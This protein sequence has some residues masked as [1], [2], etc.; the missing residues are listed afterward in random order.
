MFI[1][2]FAAC[3]LGTM[4]QGSTEAVSNTLSVGWGG[5][6]GEAVYEKFFFVYFGP[7]GSTLILGFIY[8][9][10]LMFIL[11]PDVRQEL[12]KLLANFH[13]WREERARLRAE[14]AEARRIRREADEKARAVAAEAEA[15]AVLAAE[16][17]AAA[18]AKRNAELKVTRGASPPPPLPLPPPFQPRCPPRPR[19][20]PSHR[21]FPP[22]TPLPS[23]R[24]RNPARP[25]RP[26]FPLRRKTINSPRSRSSK[27]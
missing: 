19:L 7:I 17:A 2:L 18:E 22:A 4:F 24:P 12:D 27:N 20:L 23:S 11:T 10:G 14:L 15:K 13:R 5:Q 1:C 21:A 3:G 6:V 16:A 9:I 8:L 26:A 25:S